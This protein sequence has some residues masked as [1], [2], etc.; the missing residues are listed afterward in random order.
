MKLSFI[1]AAHEVTGSCHLLEANGK[2]ILIDFWP[3]WALIK[4]VILPFQGKFYPS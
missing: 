2:N 3:L 4:A 1:G